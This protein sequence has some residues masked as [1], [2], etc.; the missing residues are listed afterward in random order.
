MHIY[1]LILNIKTYKSLD[2]LVV[3]LCLHFVK[4]SLVM[5]L[6][7]LVFTEI[8]FFKIDATL[9]YLLVSKCSWQYSLIFPWKKKCPLLKN[10]YCL[11]SC[12]D[13]PETVVMGRGVSGRWIDSKEYFKEKVEAIFLWERGEIITKKFWKRSMTRK[14]LFELI[15][16]NLF[17]NIFS[18]KD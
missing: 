16:E 12:S 1:I 9:F 4:S 11:V 13:S 14:L 2:S 5:S 6:S 7:W 10:D 8:F 15:T 18:P 3:L 17:N